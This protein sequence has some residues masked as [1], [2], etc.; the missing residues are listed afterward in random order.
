M[1]VLELSALS[2][3][4]AA[5]VAETAK[6]TV[7]ISDH[8]GARVSGFIWRTGLV[9]TAHEALADEDAFSVTLPGGTEVKGA[10]RGRDPSTDVALISVETGEFADWAPAPAPAGGSLGVVVGRGE[11]SPLARELR[12]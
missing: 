1:A 12:S 9:V 6:R 3:A 11:G 4:F 10:L 2:Q 5:L 7:S 8:E